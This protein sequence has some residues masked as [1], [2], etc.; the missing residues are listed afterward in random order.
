MVPER[1]WVIY[2]P[3]VRCARDGPPTGEVEG[4]WAPRSGG[5]VALAVRADHVG[6]HVVLLPLLREPVPLPRLLVVVRARD[7]LARE[8]AAEFSSVAGPPR[9][10]GALV[11]VVEHG[12]AL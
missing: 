12:V 2:C 10:H 7:A 9:T 1:T 3:A 6:H 11:L 8:A 4:P 5:P